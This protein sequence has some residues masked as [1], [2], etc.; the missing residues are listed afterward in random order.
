L[1]LANFLCRQA[2]I[3]LRR[4]W[5]LKDNVPT[6]WDC[7]SFRPAQQIG[8]AQHG[9]RRRVGFMLIAVI[10]VIRFSERHYTSAEDVEM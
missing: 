1:R 4:S 2:I 5:A 10:L 6:R 9:K 7:A 3:F 8:T